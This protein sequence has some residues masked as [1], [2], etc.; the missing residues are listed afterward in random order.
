MAS[1]NRDSQV[2]SLCALSNL[3][4]IYLGDNKTIAA[5]TKLALQRILADSEVQDLIGSWELV[6]GPVVD[7]FDSE[8]INTMFI[9]RLVGSSPTQYVVAIA[10]TNGKSKFDWIFEDF[11]VFRTHSWPYL[12]TI[13]QAIPKFLMPQT[14]G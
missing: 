7:S 9:A 11:S 2:F 10:G 6:W 8:S 5:N 12:P 3:S 4:D 1:Y 13:P 14:T